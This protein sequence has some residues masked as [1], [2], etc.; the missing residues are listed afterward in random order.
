MR[1]KYLRHNIK[2]LPL[3]ARL[4]KFKYSPA[5]FNPSEFIYHG[6][7]QED[8]EQVTGEIK[9]NTIRFPDFSCNWQR[10]SKPKD[11]KKRAGGLVTDGCYAFTID[12]SRYRQ[13]ATACHDPNPETDPKNYAH[14]EI[15]QLLPEESVF[16]E[17]PKKR[18]L[19]KQKQGWS[20]SQRLEYRQNIVYNLNRI[21]EP[22]A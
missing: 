15:R 16:T 18:K 17:P 6:F 12:I 20:N 4:F 10:F 9:A 14:V 8:I 2:E 19:I 1:L 11:V 5:D 22:T 13:M 21:F 7:R 3:I